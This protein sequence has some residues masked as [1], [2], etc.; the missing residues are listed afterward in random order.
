MTYN[1]E[2]RPVMWECG[3]TNIVMSFDRMGR[4]TTKNDW[5]FAHSGGNIPSGACNSPQ[6]A[7][8]RRTA[9]K[10][11]R[12]QSAAIPEKLDFGFDRPARSA[13]YVPGAVVAN[14]EELFEGARFVASEDGLR[15]YCSGNK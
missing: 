15:T 12:A 7:G 1:D 13:Y 2:N 9:S 11:G 10:Y 6:S 14:V 5:L 4:R 8:R 3:S